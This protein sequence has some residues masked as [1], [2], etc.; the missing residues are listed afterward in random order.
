[1]GLGEKRQGAGLTALAA[2]G[3]VLGAPAIAHA[4]VESWRVNE[5]ATSP[6]FVELYAPPSADADNCFFPTTHLELIDGAGV[7]THVL[8]P[9]TS[10]RCF[11]GDTY[12]VFAAAG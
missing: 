6:R 9:F 4:G 8:V 10:T 5:V 2:F 1:M 11:A 12:F 7:L 3:G